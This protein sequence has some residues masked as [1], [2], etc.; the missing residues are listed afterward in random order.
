MAKQKKSEMEL[1]H[2][3]YDEWKFRLSQYWSLT[4]KTT[5]ISFILFFIPYMKDAWG[6][7]IFGLPNRI[8]PIVAIIYSVA[9]CYIS[10]IEMN[11]INQIKNSL[12]KY[13]LEQSENLLDAPYATQNFVHQHL[14]IYI[15]IIQILIGIF[16]FHTVK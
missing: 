6:T 12:K 5:L 3:L 1:I 8:F 4:S 15:C 14:P 7:N 13:I 9:T 10:T 2:I 16:V 11:K